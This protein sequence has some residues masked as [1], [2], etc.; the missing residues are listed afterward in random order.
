[1]DAPKAKIIDW[2]RILDAYV[3]LKIEAR[4]SQL[5]IWENRNR[6]GSGGLAHPGECAPGIWSPAL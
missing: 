3:A 1:M 2:Q 4:K 6:V 5:Q